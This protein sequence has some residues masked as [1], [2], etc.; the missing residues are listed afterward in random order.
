MAAAQ[1]EHIQQKLSKKAFFH[2]LL[3]VGVFYGLLA[4]WLMIGGKATMEKQQQ[5][6]ASQTIIIHWPGDV[7]KA[8]R[9]HDLENAPH[10]PEDIDYGPLDVMESGLAAAPI[11]GLYE[12]TP[13]GHL[14]VVRQKDGLTPFA[15]YRRPF[16]LHS[17]DN[18]IIAIAITGLGLSDVATESAVR[19]MPQEISFI[20]SP[21]AP[22][23]DFWVRESRARGHEVWLS[24]PMESDRYPVDD[25]GP[26][27]MLVGAPERENQYKMEWLLSRTD[28]YIGFVTDNN[29]AFLEASNDMRPIIGNI[30]HR[31]LG[32]VDGSSHPTLIPQTMAAGQNAPY[33]SIDLWIDKDDASQRAIDAALKT[34]EETARKKGFA[35]GVIH[36]LPVSYQQVLAWTKTLKSK[37]IVLVPL[38]ATTGY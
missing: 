2:G 17:T 15:A 12:K 1:A 5:K 14:P 3:V 21:Y 35:A 10:V 24:F 28:G 25:P 32:F 19:T 16:D 34:L 11:D 7:A 20:I 8:I 9:Q 4:G 37:G 36:P 23:I 33:A 29:P 6:L 18:P 22:S 30:Y 27:T 38:S 13:D 26:H 31:G